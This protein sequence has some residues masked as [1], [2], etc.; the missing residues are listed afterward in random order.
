MA[1]PPSNGST[2]TVYRIAHACDVGSDLLHPASKVSKH[3]AMATSFLMFLR[4]RYANVISSANRIFWVYDSQSHRIAFRD[5][6]TFLRGGCQGCVRVTQEAGG[7]PALP[8]GDTTPASRGRRCL[9]IR[10]RHVGAGYSPLRYARC[11]V[12]CAKAPSL[13]HSWH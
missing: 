5:N 12:P 10:D 4:F 7:T 1:R 9:I 6:G 13:R 2:C 11:A 8:G 3:I